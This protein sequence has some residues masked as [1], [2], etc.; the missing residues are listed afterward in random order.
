MQWQRTYKMLR[1]RV[2]ESH[3]GQKSALPLCTGMPGRTGR[4]DGGPW[5]ISASPRCCC[6]CLQDHTLA[7]LRAIGVAGDDGPSGAK[8]GG[9]RGGRAGGRPGREPRLSEEGSQLGAPEAPVAPGSLGAKLQE[10]G[11]RL[12]MVRGIGHYAC[13]FSSLVV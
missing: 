4:T 6:C 10:L 2:L 7:L 11:R 8:P 1:K 5:L 12:L 9:R 3:V 13:A